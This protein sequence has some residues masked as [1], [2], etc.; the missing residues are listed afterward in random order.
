MAAVYLF[1]FNWL[2]GTA[3]LS[4]LDWLFIVLISSTVFIGDEIRKFIRKQIIKRK[5]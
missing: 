3:P 1:F 2:L 4:L 5:R